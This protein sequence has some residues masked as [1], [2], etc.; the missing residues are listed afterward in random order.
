MLPGFKLVW[1]W[2]LAVIEVHRASA[3]RRWDIPAMGVWLLFAQSE[4][5]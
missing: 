1:D 2:V 3:W 5:A 4:D